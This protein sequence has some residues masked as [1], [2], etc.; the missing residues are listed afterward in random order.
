MRSNGAVADL[1]LNS[2]GVWLVLVWQRIIIWVS[3]G[4]CRNEIIVMCRMWVLATSWLL[5]PSAWLPI[6][7]PS[8]ADSPS[9]T[10]ATATASPNR[11]GYLHSQLSMRSWSNGLSDRF[12]SILTITGNILILFF[13]HKRFLRGIMGL[14]LNF[15][16]T[17]G[18]TESTPMWS[19]TCRRARGTFWRRRR[20][21]SRWGKC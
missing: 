5:H 19:W 20:C 7:L 16:R 14:C 8:V 15:W 13:C 3:G 10:T 9:T 6:G 1:P 2:V 17:C 11:I 12:R 21:W 4:D 18:L